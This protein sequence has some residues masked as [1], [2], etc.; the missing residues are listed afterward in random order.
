MIM[1]VS[2]EE[3]HEERG[4]VT[5]CRQATDKSSRLSDFIGSGVQRAIM[6][7]PAP[8]SVS[9]KIII[10]IQTIPGVCYCN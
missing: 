10:T 3:D 6:P 2:H 7:L 8:L 4:G 1:R 9:E 5:L